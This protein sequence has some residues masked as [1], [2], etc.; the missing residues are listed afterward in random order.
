MDAAVLSCDFYADRVE[1]FLWCDTCVPAEVAVRLSAAERDL[2]PRFLR[3]GPG[4]LI[5]HR[6][7]GREFKVCA[8]CHVCGDCQPPFARS[9]AA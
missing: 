1:G 7:D 4:A 6:S 9:A 8:R 5:A 2:S 3:V